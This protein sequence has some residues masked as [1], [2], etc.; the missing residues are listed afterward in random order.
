[1]VVAVGRCQISWWGIASR[2]QRRESS[3]GALP[4]LS[5]GQKKFVAVRSGRSQDATEVFIAMCPGCFLNRLIELMILHRH[6]VDLY[7]KMNCHDPRPAIAQLVEHL[8]VDLCSN[9]MVPGSI[10]GGRIHARSRLV[11]MLVLPSF[12]SPDHKQVNLLDR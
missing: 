5:Q 7:I 2:S 4:P 9:Q 11:C 1:M 8:T 10:P 12:E 3:Q 6:F